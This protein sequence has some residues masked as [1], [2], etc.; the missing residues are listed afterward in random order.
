VEAPLEGVV[1][2]VTG[3][4]RGIGKGIALELGAAGATVY[5][6]GRTVLPGDH[7]LPGTIGDTAAAVTELGGHGVAVGCDHHVDGEV[8]AVFDRVMS[9]AGRLDLLV[10]N[11]F[12]SPT[13]IP[14]LGRPFWELPVAAWDE[15]IDIGCRSHYVAARF[16]APLL[17][18]NGRGL[19]VN[20]SSSGAVRYSH[21]VAYGV[22]KAAVDRMT[23]DMGHELAPHGVAV[24]SV[25]PGLVRTE[26]VALGAQETADGRRVLTLPGEGELDLADAESPRFTGR[27]VAA[28]A[29]DRDVLARSGR[30]FPV[31][32]LAAEY[33]FTDVDDHADGAPTR[34]EPGPSP[35]SG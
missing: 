33:G 23:A 34:T 1:A 29:A 11:V 14:W 19:I 25:W 13:M 20:V 21:N 22:G 2:V 31:A 16:A 30:A 28:L 5:V 7:P 8:E 10:N 15:T 18:A 12:S 17:L 24:V 4:S 9:E 35:G 27:A 32:Q 3:G 26:L 6:T